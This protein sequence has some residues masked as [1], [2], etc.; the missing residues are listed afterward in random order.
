MDAGF[1]RRAINAVRRDRRRRRAS[2]P[3]NAWLGLG[4]LL[5]R[6]WLCET[7][8]GRVLRK[9]HARFFTGGADLNS[10]PA[11]ARLSVPRPEVHRTVCAQERGLDYG[12]RVQRFAAILRLHL[13]LLRRRTRTGRHGRRSVSVSERPKRLLSY[14]TRFGLSSRLL[15]RRMGASHGGRWL[16]FKGIRP[17]LVSTVCKRP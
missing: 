8:L 6:L 7:R 15:H 12:P 2:R 10:T 17:G 9:T 14:P 1:E 11:R 5:Q 16:K 3:P 4:R 13:L